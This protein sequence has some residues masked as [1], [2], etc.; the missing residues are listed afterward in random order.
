M[1]LLQ[2]LNPSH[3]NTI[4]DSLANSANKTEVLDV[5][6]KVDS[7]YNSAWIKLIICLGFVNLAL[8]LFLLLIQKHFKDDFKDYFNAQLK[9]E[10]NR[11]AEEHKLLTASKF[12]E[13]KNKFLEE[14]ELF[15]KDMCNTINI[16]RHNAEAVGYHLQA[17]IS[18]DKEDYKSAY[19]NYLTTLVCCVVGK[20]KSNFNIAFQSL[21]KVFVKITK[22]DIIEINSDCSL[23]TNIEFLIYLLE[24][25]KDHLDFSGEN[26]ILKDYLQSIKYIGF[27]HNDRL[28]RQLIDLYTYSP[29]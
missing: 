15:H 2:V 3:I 11:I 1:D 14:K 18:Y 26:K 8:P 17:D 21:V 7:F 20:D 16:I 29:K 12:D 10:I 9:N 22:K 24:R 28:E 5:L 19:E 4:V 6:N 27:Y 25:N 13:L 23:Y